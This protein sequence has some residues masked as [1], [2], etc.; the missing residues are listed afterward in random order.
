MDLNRLIGDADLLPWHYPEDLKFFNEKTRGKTVLLGENTYY[1][2][3]KYY[4]GRPFPFG[5]VYLATFKR[6]YLDDV[7]IVND[8]KIFLQL[9]DEEIYVIGGK[10][11][12]ELLIPVADTIYLTLILTTHVGNMYLNRFDLSRFSLDECHLTENLLFLRYNRIEES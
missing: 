9:L 4:N 12:Y 2:L 11:I 6:N 5:K 7:T 3:K 1:S 10:Q 8:V